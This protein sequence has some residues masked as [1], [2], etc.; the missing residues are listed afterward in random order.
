MDYKGNAC[1]GNTSKCNVNWGTAWYDNIWAI[2]EGVSHLRAIHV[3]IRHVR[4][5]YVMV[6]PVLIRSDRVMHAMVCNVR[7]MRVSAEISGK[8]TTGQG[9]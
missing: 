3:M 8:G 6:I 1:K 7:E 9:T 5:M 4:S 2:H